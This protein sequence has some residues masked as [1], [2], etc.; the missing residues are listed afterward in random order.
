MVQR[1][2]GRVWGY[3]EMWRQRQVQVLSN[4]LLPVMGSL[5]LTVFRIPY[6]VY[7]LAGL[8][9]VCNVI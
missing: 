4:V 6:T 1:Q 2:Q 7:S 8:Q 3:V 9:N 5:Y